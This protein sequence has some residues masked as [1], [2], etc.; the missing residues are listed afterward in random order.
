LYDIPGTPECV[1]VA[2]DVQGRKSQRSAELP[3]EQTPGTRKPRIDLVTSVLPRSAIHVDAGVCSYVQFALDD[4][5]SVITAIEHTTVK[6]EF[7]E[8]DGSTIG[9]FEPEFS[10]I[11]SILSEDAITIDSQL[12]TRENGCWSSGWRTKP[13]AC[14]NFISAAGIRQG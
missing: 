3:P 6:D 2:G 4:H 8:P 14:H 13:G 9:M 1:G 5:V 11:R 7:G 12:N 10:D